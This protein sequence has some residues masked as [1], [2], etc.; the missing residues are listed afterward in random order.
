LNPEVLKRE[1]IREPISTGELQRRWREIRKMMEQR[2]LDALII[3]GNNQFLGGYVRYFTDTTA[4]NSY[5]QTVIF[6]K[7]EEMTII[8]SGG[9]PLTPGPP[10]WAVR[11]VKER[12]NLPYF[13][14]FWYTNTMDASL[15]VDTLKRLNAQSVGFIAPALIPAAFMEYIEE[16]LSQVH[17]EDAT[18]IV[19]LVK[20]RKSS[21]EIRLVRKAADIQDKVFGA[22]LSF[23][24]PG[25]KEFEILSKLQ[26][27]LVELGSEEQAIII[28]SAPSGQTLFPFSSFVQNRELQEGDVVYVY[29]VSSGPG[30]FYTS[31]GRIIALGKASS[32]TKRIWADLAKTKSE[33]AFMLRPGASPIKIA[34]EY[35][36]LIK[37]MGYPVNEGLIAYGQGYDFI[38]RPAIKEGEEI[39]LTSGMVIAANIELIS[40]SQNV[41]SSD[42]YFITP[43]ETVVLHKTPLTIFE[44]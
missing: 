9:L 37:N 17:F 19:D 18:D 4:E 14:S 7:S 40:N 22:A 26:R 35:N 43:E 5:P 23:I 44:I 38:E 16:K 2:N 20:A 42:T 15:A 29:I 41:Y 39:V 1:R 12:V 24:R 3:Q 30:G 28:G 25:I 6:P 11:G 21:E 32:A 27:L 10:A 31:L 34:E 8:A 36:C 33:L 13:S